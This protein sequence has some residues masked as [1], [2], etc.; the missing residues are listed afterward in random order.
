MTASIVGST[1][2]GL[3]ACSP[4]ALITWRAGTTME[5]AHGVQALY[6]RSGGA[7]TIIGQTFVHI[8]TAVAIALPTCRTGSTVEGTLSVVAGNRRVGG[9]RFVG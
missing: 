6:H 4:I 5:G 8:L 9:A 1:D 3:G 7:A 2:I